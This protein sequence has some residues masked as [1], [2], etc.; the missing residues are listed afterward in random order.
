M[1]GRRGKPFHFIEDF[2]I[3]DSELKAAALRAINIDD[4]DL[5]EEVA[6][7]L[8]NDEDDYE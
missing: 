6:I 1:T 4:E 5:L 8:K 3:D 7:Q 2:E